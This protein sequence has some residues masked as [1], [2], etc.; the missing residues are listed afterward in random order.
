MENENSTLPAIADDH[1]IAM[2]NAAER[3]IE[4]IN[5]VKGIALKVTSPHDWVDEGGRPYLQC[6]GAE[7]VARLFGISW[8]IGKPSIEVEPD[9]HYSIYYE[10]EFT[11]NKGDTITAQGK[12]S[13]KDPFFSRANDKDIPPNK[14]DRADVLQSAYTNCIGNG[15]TRFLGLRGLTWEELAPYGITRDKASSVDRGFKKD[16][17]AED[18]LLAKRMG[19]MLLDLTEP[20]GDKEL[21]SDLLEKLSGFT[22]RD[23]KEVKGKRKLSELTGK[24]LVSTYGK[25][26]DAY[27][28]KY[29]LTEADM[30]AMFAKTE[31]AAA[32][33]PA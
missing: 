6:S 9:G 20:P 13:S 14:I 19:N 26:K 28:K 7:K 31:K 17:T 22:G 12:R 25:V 4:A 24:W 23:G 30:E 1:V 15:I 16:Q 3:R 18:K 33:V 29:G 27:M 5:K 32:V 21:A 8:R 11:N 10:G 2:A